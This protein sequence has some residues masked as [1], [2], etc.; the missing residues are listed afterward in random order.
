MIFNRHFILAS[1]LASFAMAAFASGSRLV[2]HAFGFDVLRD[3]PHVELLDYRYGTSINPGVKPPDWALKSGKIRQQASTTG[4]MIVG[5][6]LYAKWKVRET[7]EVIEDTVNLKSKLPNDITNHRIY[8]VI[9]GRK[10]HAYLVSPDL[11]PSDFP[12]AGPPKF[13]DKKVYSLYP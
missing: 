6:T 7:E 11:R 3:S 13:H 12:I 10:L 8:F 4:E 9:E 2:D 5:D 1:F